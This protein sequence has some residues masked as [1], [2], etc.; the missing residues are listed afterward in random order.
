MFRTVSQPFSGFLSPLDLTVGV[1]VFLLTVCQIFVRR[2]I[3]LLHFNF[4]NWVKRHFGRDRFPA[5]DFVMLL[6]SFSFTFDA[7]TNF[8]A[9]LLQPFEATVIFL[10]NTQQAK[11]PLQQFFPFMTNTHPAS[12]YPKYKVSVKISKS[13]TIYVG[14]QR[15]LL[16]VASC[17][18]I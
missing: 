14:V 11:Y 18:R 10:T 1:Q 6:F 7:W 3:Q 15:F 5:S 16:N 12:N 9:L 4:Q 2:H 8:E 13:N 17:A